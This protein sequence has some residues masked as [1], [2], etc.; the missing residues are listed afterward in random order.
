MNQNELDMYDDFGIEEDLFIEAFGNKKIK[1]MS[2]NQELK[3]LKNIEDF[4]KGKQVTKDKVNYFKK[5]VRNSRL[6]HTK[7]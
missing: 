3:L 6:H 5:R 1:R 2:Y 7:K 4:V